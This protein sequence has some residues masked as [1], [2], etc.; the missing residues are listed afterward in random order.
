MNRLVAASL[1][2]VA[3]AT[4]GGFM[5]S[6]TSA[7]AVSP[8]VA[9]A[10]KAFVK[11]PA[12]PAGLSSGIEALASY[13]PVNSCDA[14][15]KPGSAALAQ[16]LKATY[17]ESS[18]GISRPCERDGLPTTEHN[19]GRAVDLMSSVRVPVQKA[20]AEAPCGERPRLVLA[21][22]S[23]GLDRIRLGERRIEGNS[24]EP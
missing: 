22:S 3:L 14:Q 19:E 16:V 18:Y 23:R 2:G 12:V 7:G 15:D 10:V 8:V 11:L 9:A 6:M 4:G 13:V 21:G 1:V 17:P 24:K 20:N 5:G